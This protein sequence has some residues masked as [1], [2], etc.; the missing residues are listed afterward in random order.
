[1]ASRST[2]SSCRHGTQ[3]RYW[4]RSSPI[5]AWFR[6]LQAL[7]WGARLKQHNYP[8]GQS[9][10]ITRIS[11]VARVTKFPPEASHSPRI[12]RYEVTTH[13]QHQCCKHYPCPATFPISRK[14]GS[15]PAIG[16]TSKAR[17]RPPH[18]HIHRCT[19]PPPCIFLSPLHFGRRLNMRCSWSQI[20][21]Q[22]SPMTYQPCYLHQSRSHR[23]GRPLWRPS[24]GKGVGRALEEKGLAEGVANFSPLSCNLI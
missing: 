17:V 9:P 20:G 23:V 22:T 1:V 3:V 15:D 6:R 5:L 24:D 11:L 2:R 12:S 21:P 18:S 13:T 14:V 10:C 4:L 16:H 19:H 8:V 7:L